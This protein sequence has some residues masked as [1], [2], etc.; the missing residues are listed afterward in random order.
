MQQPRRIT[1]DEFARRLR[2]VFDAVQREKKPVLV[3]REGQLFRVERESLREAAD[4]WARYS[5]ER[6]RAGLRRSAGAFRGLD[7]EAFLADVKE[8]REQESTGRP[9]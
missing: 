3:E 1:F 7:R 4:I 6:V 2:A 5:P 8:Q 9:A